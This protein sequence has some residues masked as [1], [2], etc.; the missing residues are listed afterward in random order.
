MDKPLIPDHDG[1]YECDCGDQFRDIF[2]FLGHNDVQYEWGVRLTRNYTFD[3]F[4]FLSTLNNLIMENK[5]QDAYECVQS[6]AL[7]FMNAGEGLLADFMEEVL[8]HTEMHEVY[9]GLEKMLIEEG[10]KHDK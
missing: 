6:T 5:Y 8:V 3:V 10:K 4:Q 2:D 7:V 9:N 1:R